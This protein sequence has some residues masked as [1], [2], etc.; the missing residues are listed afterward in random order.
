MRHRLY[1]YFSDRKWA[2]AFLDGEILFRSLSYFRDYEDKNVRGDEKEGTAVYRPKEGLV[3]TNH[4][5]GTTFTLSDHAL[6]QPRIRKSSCF[7]QA[8]RY[9]TKWRDSKPLPASRFS[10]SEIYVADRIG[11]ALLHSFADSAFRYVLPR[12]RRRQPALG[13]ARFDRNIETR[14]LCLAG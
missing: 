4:T 6:S 11:L 5:Q 3:I 2:N 1:K 14:K 8:D 7:A 12:E 13:L 9:P 10:T